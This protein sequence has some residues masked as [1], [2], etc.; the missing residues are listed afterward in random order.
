MYIPKDSD[1]LYADEKIINE[2]IYTAQML[3][4]SVLFDDFINPNYKEAFDNISIDSTEL[5]EL[6]KKYCEEYIKINEILILMQCNKILDGDSREYVFENTKNKNINELAEEMFC[7]LKRLTEEKYIDDEDPEEDFSSC[8]INC[9]EHIRNIADIIT[10]KK[11][12]PALHRTQLLNL[13]NYLIELNEEFSYIRDYR[14]GQ[15]L[16]EC[17]AEEA[18][19]YEF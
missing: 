4:G 13:F 2:K 15:I 18:N 6:V 5:S 8:I 10:V 17:L 16:D 14:L 3:T 12:S 1:Q 7:Q 11:L 19:C 9:K